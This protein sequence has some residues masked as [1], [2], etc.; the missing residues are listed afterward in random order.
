M[1]NNS[2]EVGRNKNHFVNLQFK[3]INRHGLITG[4]TGSGKTVTLQLIVEQLSR[5]GIPV[6][7]PDVKGDLI[8]ISNAGV[9]S[10]EALQLLSQKG[11]KEPLWK[12]CP[13][14]LWS[15]GE[16]QNATR[17]FAKVLTVGPLLMSRL[18]N[19]SEVQTSVMQVGFRISREQQQPISTLSELLALFGWMALNRESLSATYGSFQ[20]ST[21]STIQRALVILEEQHG[22]HF[23]SKSELKLE[24]LMKKDGDE[25]IVN[26]LEARSLLRHP[27]LY[28]VA[29]SWLLERLYIELDE[30]GDL[31]KPRLV[32]FIDE[33]HLLFESLGKSLQD[34]LE[35]CIRLIRS[36]GVGVFFVSQLP[37]DI[38]ENVLGQLGNRIQHVLRAYTPKD[39]KAV[40]VAAQTMR[41]NPSLNI[42]SSITE[43]SPGEALV[44]LLYEDGT[45]TPT[46]RI[47]INMPG[48][49]IG[50]NNS[51]NL[52]PPLNTSINQIEP[53]EKPYFTPLDSNFLEPVLGKPKPE[54]IEDIKNIKIGIS[55]TI[56][57]GF[58]VTLRWLFNIFKRF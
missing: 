25:G 38:P 4:A 16:Q 17:M 33:A 30:V 57:L 11:L 46:Q 58:S 6:F 10:P 14:R 49:Q 1:S 29:F 35:R 22:G 55:E 9:S 34:N 15:I 44:S 56:I 5:A 13:V 27:T 45:P 26:L 42:E 51:A 41:S 18:L 52:L 47:W 28:A 50:A 7:A 12:A 2:L 32:I 36:K 20:D 54:N 19:L 21:I 40:R 53:K 24:D 31:D 3:Y 48:S 43:L 8:G 39:Q 23:F 37:S